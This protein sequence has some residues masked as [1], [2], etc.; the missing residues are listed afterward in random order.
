MGMGNFGI[1][2]AQIGQVSNFIKNNAKNKRA[3]E[4]KQQSSIDI[5]NSDLS[6]FRR[7]DGGVSFYGNVMP[8]NVSL[9]LTRQNSGIDVKKTSF[10]DTIRYLN[11]HAAVELL[12]NN[13]SKDLYT[14]LYTDN[15]KENNLK[16]ELKNEN[17]DESQK[18]IDIP[19]ERNNPFARGIES[20]FRK[21]LQFGIAA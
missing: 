11:S 6:A 9:N 14:F 19:K 1:D 7:V 12:E 5:K 16:E 18:S 21:N 10:Q 20:E 3:D 4:E 15:T 2:H 8:N 17:K 13:K